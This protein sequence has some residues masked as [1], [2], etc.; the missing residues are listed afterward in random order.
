LQTEAEWV[1]IEMPQRRLGMFEVW[2][3]TRNEHG[4]RPHVHVFYA[5]AE[6]VIL[7]GRRAEVRENPG[8]MKIKDVCDAQVIVAEHRDEL[9]KL[10]RRYN[11]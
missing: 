2:V 10:W 3:Y 1:I 7:I 5:G 8:D 9:L 4:H 11:G 6:V